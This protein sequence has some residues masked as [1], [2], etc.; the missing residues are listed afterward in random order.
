MSSTLSS[1]VGCHQTPFSFQ[2]IQHL[3]TS[4]PSLTQREKSF[5]RVLLT[6]AVLTRDEKKIYKAIVSIICD[7]IGC[8]VDT[9]AKRRLFQK[10]PRVQ[11]G[12]TPE[13]QQQFQRLLKQYRQ[14]PRQVPT[15]VT[16]QDDDAAAR[17]F[18]QELNRLRRQQKRHDIQRLGELCEKDQV[19]KLR[20]RYTPLS[21]CQKD[22]LNTLTQRP[23]QK[24]SKDDIFLLNEL[25][26]R[27]K[28]MSPLE[29]K[30]L[31]VLSVKTKQQLTP[32]EHE[33]LDTLQLI[34]H[35]ME[36]GKTH[37]PRPAHTT[38]RSSPSWRDQARRK[39]GSA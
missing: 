31:N 36:R 20:M 24:M 13:Q 34:K 39:G 12:L 16:S 18:Q 19:C 4:S 23:P 37:S 29:Q 1:S 8:H 35:F 28:R 27:D 7:D 2:N 15:S 6:K 14:F 25:V 9:Q 22:L 33:I 10:C 3:L 11:S 21:Y 26:R 17:L 32:Q 5:F 38:K 30:I